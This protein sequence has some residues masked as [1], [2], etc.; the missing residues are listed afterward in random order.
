M[1]GSAVSGPAGGGAGSRSPSRPHGTGPARSGRC[2]GCRGRSHCRRCRTAAARRQAAHQRSRP[3]GPHL[4]DGPRPRAGPAPQ[5]HGGPGRR[6]RIGLNQHSADVL[7][8]RMIR[9]DTDHVM[10]LP[11]AQAHQHDPAG[12]CPVNRIGQVRSDASQPRAQRRRRIIIGRVP[13]QPVLHPGIV[14]PAAHVPPPQAG[15]PAGTSRRDPP[16]IP[17]RSIPA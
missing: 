5:P 17:A 6:S 13:R 12:R 10:T 8:A 4:P 1:P 15:S 11:G 2:A 14:A 7:A 3:P 9:Q 16:G